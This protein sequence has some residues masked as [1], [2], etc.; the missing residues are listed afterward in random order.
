MAR[1][2]ANK[3]ASQDI[4]PV[5][6]EDEVEDYAHP[7]NEQGSHEETMGYNPYTGSWDRKQFGNEA[8]IPDPWEGPMPPIKRPD[9]TDHDYDND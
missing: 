7:E 1:D 8:F 6:Q 4:A 5:V 9:D 3:K 2:K